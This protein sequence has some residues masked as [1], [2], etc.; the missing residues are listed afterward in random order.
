M[1]ASLA[2]A[3]PAFRGMSV[4]DLMQPWLKGDFD[5]ARQYYIAADSQFTH[6]YLADMELELAHY[7][8]CSQILKDDSNKSEPGF[9]M[10][11]ARL[12][13]QTGDLA[14]AEKVISKTGLKHS[15]RVGLHLSNTLALVALNRG[16]YAEAKELFRK[17]LWLSRKPK[18]KIDEPEIILGLIG[19]A[20]TY[21]ALGNLN[22]ADEFAGKAL[23][24]STN[25]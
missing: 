14:T 23:V 2:S 1:L 8:S 7:R 4:I 13:Y 22:T 16:Q 11:R 9:A 21:L 10:R 24:L 6:R 17:R 18:A 15:G 19:L 25:S 12:L 5:K 20:R 3:Q